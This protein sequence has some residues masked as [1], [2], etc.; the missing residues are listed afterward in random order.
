MKL[1]SK[2]SNVS[3]ACIPENTTLMRYNIT[4]T[5][6]T[7]VAQLIIM[8]IGLLRTRQKRQRG[9]LRYMCIQVGGVVFRVSPLTMAIELGL[10]VAHC[11]DDR[12]D[13]I[14]GGFDFRL[15]LQ[16]G[17]YLTIFIIVTLL[18]RFSST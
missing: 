16:D 13:S 6:V 15:R 7:D 4:V 5:T 10:D 3:K 8:L 11:C 18:T 1:R 17:L 12:G 2:W 9:L 14:C